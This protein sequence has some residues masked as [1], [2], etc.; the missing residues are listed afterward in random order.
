[1]HSALTDTVIR[2]LKAVGRYTDTATAGLNLQ[3]KIG[4]GKYW[5]FRYQFDGKRHD[6]SLGTYP[7]VSLKEARVRATNARYELNRGQ[8]PSATWKPQKVAAT[9][10]KNE[11]SPIFSV[12]AKSCID[13]LNC[14][15]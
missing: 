1:M 14:I 7:Q 5:T 11:T 15:Q 13:M 8:R 10:N 9:A 4:G 2:N 6:L 3:V 12:F